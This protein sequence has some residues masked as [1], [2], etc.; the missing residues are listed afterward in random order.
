MSP[1]LMQWLDHTLLA[2]AAVEGSELKAYIK[3]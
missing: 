3:E 2:T 1:I